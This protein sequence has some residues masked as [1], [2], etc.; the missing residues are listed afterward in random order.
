MEEVQGINS[1]FSKYLNPREVDES[2][3]DKEMCAKCGG[4]C[5]KRMG[6]HFR[7]Q[8]FKNLTAQSLIDFIDESQCV[9]IDW[10]E[11]NPLDENDESIER[12]YFL[13]VRNKDGRIV[14]GA[15][16]GECKLL[17]TNGCPLSDE[18]RPHGGY[19][20]VPAK[21]A[22][23]ECVSEYTKQQCV[24][25]W[26]QYQDV[27]REVVEHYGGAH[28]SI[29]DLMEGFLGMYKEFVKERRDESN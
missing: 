8:D 15:W 25:E 23:S 11:G 26:L 1:V 2:L 24:T 6:C 16:V 28:M 22:D 5:C 12:T 10:W 14:E 7:P 20:L 18:Y 4:R 9:S 29:V 27:L 3:C 13:R 17:E 21:D 19:T